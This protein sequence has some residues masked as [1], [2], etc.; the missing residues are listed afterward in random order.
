MKKNYLNDDPEVCEF[1]QNRLYLT[2]G[3]VQKGTCE[4]KFNCPI[5]GD[6]KKIRSKMR[7]SYYP[8]TNSFKC[9]NEGCSASGL[10]IIAKFENKDISEVKR[11]FLDSLNKALKA[12]KNNTYSSVISEILNEPKPDAS[13]TERDAKLAKAMSH[14]TDLPRSVEYNVRFE[15]KLY[16]APFW[17]KNYKLRFDT[18]KCRLVI[19][20][21][22]EQ[23]LRFFQNRAIRKDQNPKYDSSHESTG[24][25][26]DVFNF[27]LLDENIKEAYLLEGAFDAVW[28][29]N[30]LAIAGVFITEHQQIVLDQ[31]PY[32]KYIYMYDNQYC[33][34]A[35]LTK[36]LKLF[37]NNQSASSFVWP[38]E[39]ARFKDVNQ[40]AIEA[41]EMISR[42]ADPVWLKSRTFN[43]IAGLLE[44]E[45]AKELA[46]L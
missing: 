29:K 34:T 26:K 42:F 40:V 22:R 28:V 18:E 37:K 1:V 39:L 41:P 44:L 27:D 31:K 8:K 4:W 2:V 36:T 43:G 38:R 19:P 46:G 20:W 10:F 45:K 6:S 11:D 33:D 25:I 21:Y 16:E 23:K 35:G 14:W 32:F 5:C 7:G 3:R 12:N 17:P 13:T 9:F 24:L 30:G 15:R